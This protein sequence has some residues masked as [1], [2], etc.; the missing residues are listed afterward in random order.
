MK[1]PDHPFWDF[2]LALYARPNVA[3]ACLRLQDKLGVDVNL[4]LFACWAAANHRQ[5]TSDGWRRLV[6]ETSAWRVEVVEPLRRVRRFLTS[7]RSTPWSDG[8][9]ERV[10]ALELDAE[11]VEQLTIV[12]LAEPGGET[13]HAPLDAMLGY[14]AVLDVVPSD[15]DRSDLSTIA[16]QAARM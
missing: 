7:T 14:I 15:A 13:A 16:S 9:R 5:P 2:S 6:A 8:L 11:H 3:E 10:A 12:A 1:F 4:I